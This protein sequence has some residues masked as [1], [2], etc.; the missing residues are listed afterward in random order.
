MSMASRGERAPHSSPAELAAW[1][2]LASPR[3]RV[4]LELLALAEGMLARD[5]RPHPTLC[6]G[7]AL[8]GDLVVRDLELDCGRVQRAALDLGVL[9]GAGP[10]RQPYLYQRADARRFALDWTRSGEED[11]P[12]NADAS[13]GGPFRSDFEQRRTAL[14]ADPR[15]DESIPSAQLHLALLRAHN[16]LVDRGA[17]FEEARRALRL[18]AQHVAL[19]DW[20]PKLCAPDAIDEAIERACA[21]RPS[22][23]EMSMRAVLD[24][25]SHGALAFV[26]ALA[27]KQLALSDAMPRPLRLFRDLSLASS[28]EGG[29]ELPSGWAVQWDRLVPWRGSTPQ[30]AM[31]I[32][33]GI[34]RPFKRVPGPHWSAGERHLPYRVL[35][36]AFERGTPSGQDVARALGERAHGGDEPLLL[37]VLN[38]AAEQCDGLVLGRVGSRLVAHALVSAIAA[39]EDSLFDAPEFAP[40]LG[41]E[42]EPFTLADLIAIG[43]AP[44]TRADWEARPRARSA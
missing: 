32:D 21:D 4:E 9:Y 29:R 19:R 17:S 27:P 22:S 11:L 33:A 16:A 14:V 20:L 23:A 24:V 7:D 40:S 26:H 30:P 25:A 8:F 31:R 10:R 18:H 6:A 39:S 15:S 43:G 1:R 37:Y 2:S 38:E 44:M 36:Q 34:A 41:R 3:E 12:R 5:K 13:L 28:L 35:R 42:G